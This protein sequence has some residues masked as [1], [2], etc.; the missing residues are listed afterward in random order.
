MYH[1]YIWLS[2]AITFVAL[3]WFEHK[4]LT[5]GGLFYGFGFFFSSIGFTLSAIGCVISILIGAV[6]L[7]KSLT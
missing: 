2:L 5:N 6:E 4:Q 7:F 1:V 3:V